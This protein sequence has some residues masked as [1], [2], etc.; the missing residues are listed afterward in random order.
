MQ[1]GS[2]PGRGE[3]RMG[4]FRVKEGGSSIVRAHAQRPCS[5]CGDGAWPVK[6]SIGDRAQRVGAPVAGAKV[7]EVGGLD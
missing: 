5:G 6:K 1:C 4:W 3:G 7:R 2:W